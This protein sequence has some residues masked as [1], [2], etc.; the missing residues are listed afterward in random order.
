[1]C[2]HLSN[3]LYNIHT[4]YHPPKHCMLIIQ[5][6]GGDESYKE[7]TAISISTPVCHGDCVGSIMFQVFVKFVFKVRPPDALTWKRLGLV[8]NQSELII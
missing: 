3:L 1:M 5:P 7:L 4:L 6:G 2:L 8:N